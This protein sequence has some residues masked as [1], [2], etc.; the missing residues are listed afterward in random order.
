MHDFLNI[1]P[2]ICCRAALLHPSSVRCRQVAVRP[3]SAH[4][5]THMSRQVLTGNGKS[6]PAS[7]L[8]QSDWEVGCHCA[9]G[10]LVAQVMMVIIMHTGFG[11][12]GRLGH[13]VQQDEHKPKKIAV[14]DRQPVDKDSIV[15]H[16]A[17]HIGIFKILK[18]SQSRSL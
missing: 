5:I 6:S 1:R 17:S 7:F 9:T 2:S 16:L 8:I 18:L 10:H 11:G 14:F 3:C 13:T 4:S 12:Y 15:R